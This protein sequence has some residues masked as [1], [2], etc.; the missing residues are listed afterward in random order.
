MSNEVVNTEVENTEATENASPVNDKRRAELN[1]FVTK[2]GNEAAFG[3]DSL[4]KLA[5]AVVKAAADGV[6]TPDD[7][8]ALYD[9]YAMAESSKAIHEHSAGGRRAN[10]SKLKQL[11]IMGAMTTVDAVEV[12]QTAFDVRQR[13][14]GMEDGPKL[15]SAYPFY[16]DVARA[17]Q[18]T[19]VP[20][21]E[22][23]LEEIAAK[24]EPKGKELEAEL[25]AIAKR[26]EALVTGENKNG[27]KD[28]DDNTEAAFHLIKERCDK[29][30]KL[31]LIQKAAQM[32]LKLA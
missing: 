22:Q 24:P 28:D 31:R 29:F 3:K 12:M 7:A 1:K 6:I 2:L 4:P 23:A 14:V 9:R 15:K 19:D 18:K 26:L 27:L 17:Q 16:V 25:L 20:L 30:A 21:T 5:H 11:V 13:L 8:E 10:I 32:G